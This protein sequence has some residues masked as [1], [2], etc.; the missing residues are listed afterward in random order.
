MKIYSIYDS[1]AEAYIRPMFSDN[2]G[3]MTREFIKA[4]N[5]TNSFMN[6]TPE[7]FTLFEIGEWDERT[8]SIKVYESKVSLG[9]AVEYKK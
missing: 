5:D 3:T 6:S 4:V 1:K 7:D 9:C 8:G 2:K